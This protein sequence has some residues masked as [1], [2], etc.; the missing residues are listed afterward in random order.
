MS[1]SI[2]NARTIADLA[3][4]S[5]DIKTIDG[6]PFIPLPDDYN[7]ANLEHYLQQPT[8][9]RGNLKVKDVKSFLQVFSLH[10]N[11]NTHIYADNDT[12]TIQAVFNDHASNDAGHR[13]H[14][15][16]YQVKLS[17]EWKIWNS[18]N[19][20]EMAQIEFASFIECNLPDITQPSSSD[21]LLISRTLQAK[22]NVSFSSAVNLHNGANQFSYEETVKGTTLDGK[23]EIPEKFTI[24]IN[25]FFNEQPFEIQAKFRYRIK[26]SQLL[27]GYELIR[28]QEVYEKAFNNI[29]AE[30]EVKTNHSI[31]NACL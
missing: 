9:K 12:A 14:L 27:M 13:D 17:P 23:I 15:L 24:G 10:A 1:E 29:L 8:R 22:K 21:M 18:R 26:D 31:I 7:V 5:T 19:G 25:V 20:K 28:E 4:S 16:T 11:E 6:V 3:I 2:N 30:I